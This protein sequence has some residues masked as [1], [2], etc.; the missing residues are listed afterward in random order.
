MFVGLYF[1]HFLAISVTIDQT[2]CHLSDGPL[3]LTKFVKQNRINEAK[4]ASKVK[5]PNG[6][7]IDSYSGYFNVN[8][9]YNSNLFFWFFPSQV[10]I[11]TFE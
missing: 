11:G 7:Q 9:Q 6:P 1:W 10:Q 4:S 3:I 2:V 5:L 8:E